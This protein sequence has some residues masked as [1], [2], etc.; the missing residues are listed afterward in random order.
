MNQNYLIPANTKK[1]QLILGL[2][3]PIDLIIF[4]SGL[5]VTLILVMI[6]PME[7]IWVALLAI[8]PGIITGLLV[9]PVANYHNVRQLIIEIYQYFTKRNRFV[10]KGWCFLDESESKQMD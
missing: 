10:W 4:G 7:E 5:F 2:F 8:T 3:Y 6:L 1:G 9:L